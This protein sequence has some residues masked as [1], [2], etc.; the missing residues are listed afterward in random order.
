MIYNLLLKSSVSNPLCGDSVHWQTIYIHVALSHCIYESLLNFN[1]VFLSFFSGYRA[2]PCSASLTELVDADVVPS[3]DP[4]LSASL[5]GSIYLQICSVDG[6]YDDSSDDSASFHSEDWYCE[7]VGEDFEAEAKTLS[8]KLNVNPD[9]VARVSEKESSDR[10][11]NVAKISRSEDTVTTPIAERS[12]TPVDS[13]MD[14][15][16]KKS[17]AECGDCADERTPTEADQTTMEQDT[18]MTP[19]PRT[20]VMHPHKGAEST[21]LIFDPDSRREIIPVENPKESRKHSSSKTSRRKKHKESS[22]KS[23]R[24]K[25]RERKVQPTELGSDVVG[26]TSPRDDTSIRRSPMIIKPVQDTE[27]R[28]VDELPASFERPSTTAHRHYS[29]KQR[30]TSIESERNVSGNTTDL[31]R[32]KKRSISLDRISRHN[33]SISLDTISRRTISAQDAVDKDHILDRQKVCMKSHLDTVGGELSPEVGHR[34]I[35]RSY[36]DLDDCDATS[37]LRASVPGRCTRSNEHETRLERPVN[38]RQARDAGVQQETAVRERDTKHSRRKRRHIPVVSTPEEHGVSRDTDR[39]AARDMSTIVERKSDSPFG[40]RGKGENQRLREDTCGAIGVD[41]SDNEIGFSEV[42]QMSVDIDT[43]NCVKHTNRK[44]STGSRHATKEP[45]FPLSGFVKYCF[46]ERRKGAYRKRVNAV[47]KSQVQEVVED[48]ECVSKDEDLHDV[49]VVAPMK[50]LSVLSLPTELEASYIESPFVR[51]LHLQ[52]LREWMS[53]KPLDSLL[54]GRGQPSSDVPRSLPSSSRTD[55]TVIDCSTDFSGDL[56]RLLTDGRCGSDDVHDLYSEPG[57]STQETVHRVFR[58]VRHYMEFLAKKPLHDG[59]G[60]SSDKRS[61]RIEPCSKIENLQHAGEIST[62]DGFTQASVTESCNDADSAAYSKKQRKLRKLKHRKDIAEGIDSP[63][64][65]DP[66]TL[67]IPLES[68]QGSVHHDPRAP[69]KTHRLKQ[70]DDSVKSIVSEF[71]EDVDQILDANCVPD[72]HARKKSRKRSGKHLSKRSHF[73]K[74]LTK[75]LKAKDRDGHEDVLGDVSD[76]PLMDVV[77]EGTA[78]GRTDP[79][80]YSPTRPTENDDADLRLPDDS[81]PQVSGETKEAKRKTKSHTSHGKSKKRKT[82]TKSGEYSKL[83]AGRRNKDKR[84]LSEE[85]VQLNV[86]DS[87]TWKENT[88]QIK[89]KRSSTD[90]RRSNSDPV[91]MHEKY[92]GEY[93]SASTEYSQPRR[94]GNVDKHSDQMSRFRRQLRSRRSCF[95]DSYLSSSCDAFGQLPEPNFDSSFDQTRSPCER[96]HNPYVLTGP[97]L[98]YFVEKHETPLTSHVRRFCPSPTRFSSQSLEPENSFLWSLALNSVKPAIASPEKSSTTTNDALTDKCEEQVEDEETVTDLSA[99]LLEY[100]SV[101]PSKKSGPVK[102]GNHLMQAFRQ[103]VEAKKRASTIRTTRAAGKSVVA[104]N[105]SEKRPPP[106]IPVTLFKPPIAFALTKQREDAAKAEAASTK[107]AAIPRNGGHRFFITLPD[108][109]E[110]N[111][112][113]QYSYDNVSRQLE[114]VV[115]SDCGAP[116]VNGIVRKDSDVVRHGLTLQHLS[117]LSTMATQMYKS[118]RDSR[119]RVKP[120]ND[121]QQEN[122]S[123]TNAVPHENRS[124]RTGFVPKTHV[125]VDTR[126]PSELTSEVGD[127]DVLST[128]DATVVSPERSS[129][130]TKD[131]TEVSPERSSNP[132]KDATIV[133]SIDPTNYSSVKTTVQHPVKDSDSFVPVVKKKSKSEAQKNEPAVALSFDHFE[134]QEH[135]DELPEHKDASPHKRSMCLGEAV[136]LEDD[137]SSKAALMRLEKLGRS[138]GSG[139]LLNIIP[140]GEKLGSDDPICAEETQIE[141]DRQDSAIVMPCVAGFDADAAQETLEPPPASDDVSKVVAQPSLPHAANNDVSKVVVESSLPQAANDEVSKVVAQPSMPQFANDDV[142]KVVVEPSLPLVAEEKPRA[143]VEQCVTNDYGSP[144]DCNINEVAAEKL[145]PKRSKL[146]QAFRQVVAAKNKASPEKPQNVFAKQKVFHLAAMHH[147]SKKDLAGPAKKKSKLTIDIAMVANLKGDSAVSSVPEAKREDGLDQHGSEEGPVGRVVTAGGDAGERK[148]VK[149]NEEESEEKHGVR[150][151]MVVSQWPPPRQEPSSQSK[152]D[153]LEKSV[154]SITRAPARVQHLGHIP[155]PSFAGQSPAVVQNPP[156]TTPNPGPRRSSD[157]SKALPLPS[158]SSSAPPLPL[159][160]LVKPPLPPD[161]ST[162]PPLPPVL[163]TEPQLPPTPLPAPPPPPDGLIAPPLP[164]VG[165]IGPPPLPMMGEAFTPTKMPWMTGEPSEHT[166]RHLQAMSSFLNQRNADTAAPE[167]AGGSYTDTEYPPP[168]DTSNTSDADAYAYWCQQY[169]SQAPV[170]PYS[171]DYGQWGAYYNQYQQQPPTNNDNPWTSHPGTQEWPPATYSGQTGGRKRR[172][173]LPNPDS[174]PPPSWC[175]APREH[176]M[177]PPLQPAM[178]PPQS[179]NMGP[180]QPQTTGP[181]QQTMGPP[182][183]T[184]GPPP[185]PIRGPPPTMGPPPSTPVQHGGD[186][187]KKRV[188][189]KKPEVQVPLQGLVLG[190]DTRMYVL[191]RDRLVCKSIEVSECVSRCFFP[192]RF[193]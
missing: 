90:N 111:D 168:Y 141:C 93:K 52:A 183:Q 78:V 107:A 174:E 81:L 180:P 137:S 77:E 82:R 56:F 150:S 160:S 34:G 113:A 129:N 157:T 112:V 193:L 71:C 110:V 142:S 14:E 89:E 98:Q 19:Q 152:W 74:R 188:V 23:H 63:N 145:T 64:P 122:Q 58:Q 57:S 24:D 185:Q 60:A 100:Q 178:G 182:Q 11:E 149:S 186:T 177:G 91:A 163:S 2:N 128:E 80:L 136:G 156:S 61:S 153:K 175:D 139:L 44:D 97:L 15:Q 117:P 33:R 159:D 49:E 30:C 25:K 151:G 8:V 7:D 35:D 181:P 169:Y 42:P 190:N 173:L 133:S 119:D 62:V 146:L 37:E 164:P 125:I 28:C 148:R 144:Q 167:Q 73:T 87:Q 124:N 43:E 116:V 104:K 155:L 138:T 20:S 121:V 29:K 48:M 165:L 13:F 158:D 92:A 184:V 68:E 108:M 69:A 162:G 130:P 103:A 147:L 53:T 191:N 161:A 66:P 86:D 32:R 9:Y 105:I 76:T 72:D 109:K 46:H 192:Q 47:V 126:T 27:G 176:S 154:S 12:V 134:D 39:I 140:L 143:T 3:R 187:E 75:M 189:G 17:D 88:P 55:D 79:M 115:V 170:D 59:N 131:A 123:K 54:I 179:P 118:Q 21:L 172:F 67:E 45:T 83:R 50:H 94:S 101:S 102:Q 132:T 4:R 96:N 31:P 127:T 106:K 16:S 6:A 18:G 84:R 171:Y 70:I 114:H 51:Q 36:D 65:V 166:Q 40:N 5:P 10:D 26:P 99:V 120:K 95:S 1:L 22:K 41:R 38:I 135:S 85:F